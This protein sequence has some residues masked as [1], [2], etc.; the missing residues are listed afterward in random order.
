MT[1]HALGDYIPPLTTLIR[2][3]TTGLR[4]S[5]LQL[6][7][8][9]TNYLLAHDIAV[10]YLVP[11]PLHW[12]KK[13]YRGFNQSE[14]IAHYIAQ[15]MDKQ[16]LHAVSKTRST[17]N[18][19]SLPHAQRSTNLLNAFSLTPSTQDRVRDKHIL[20]IDDV[21]TT[22][23]TLTA[24]GRQLIKAKPASLAALVGARVLD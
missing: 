23:S 16:V 14:E 1:V 5:T 9:M 8:L 6:A 4:A 17:A 11:V 18:Q 15:K 12:A 22:G 2:A 7:Q 20:L 13:V 3:K 24:V 19:S 10:D 21:M